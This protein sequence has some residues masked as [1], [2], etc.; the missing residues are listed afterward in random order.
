M[1]DPVGRWLLLEILFVFLS[2]FC[3][4]AAYAVRECSES[5]LTEAAE[6]GDKK[7]AKMLPVVQEPDDFCATLRVGAVGFGF[8]ALMNP[9]T[10]GM[11]QR[12]ESL[13]PASYGVQEFVG[14]VIWVVLLMLGVAL[15]DLTTERYAW[16]RADQVVRKVF[17]LACVL[18]KLLRPVSSP[19]SRAYS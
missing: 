5:K 10:A 15:M 8:F 7:A 3:A 19:T 17:G 12:V 13:I 18:E 1:S 14:G 4:L 2:V 16:H 6:E 9:L 11:I